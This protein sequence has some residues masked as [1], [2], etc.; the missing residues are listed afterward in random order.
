MGAGIIIVKEKKEFLALISKEGLYDLPKGTTEEGESPF[1]TAQRECYE[2]CSLWITV[3]DLLYETYL[4]RNGTQIFI[5]QMPHN[6]QI[7]IKVNEE[8]G[9]AEHIGWCWITSEEFLTNTY[10]FLKTH[11]KWASNLISERFSS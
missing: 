2:E 4:N 3:S 5:A 6:Q 9:K 1:E 8:T 11:I 10:P 7:E